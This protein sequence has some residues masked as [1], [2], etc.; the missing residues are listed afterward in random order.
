MV[1]PAFLRK[2]AILETNVPERKRCFCP[3]P[4]A[5]DGTCQE[6]G[7]ATG[8]ASRYTNPGG[9]MRL[10]TDDNCHGPAR[11]SGGCPGQC[12]G[13]DRSDASS[14]RGS[15]SYSKRDRNGRRLPSAG[16]SRLFVSGGDCYGSDAVPSLT[17]QGDERVCA[18]AET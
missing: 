3:D 11:L 4:P 16:V 18:R 8:V 12:P 2:G 5:T 15:R 14:R 10:R 9:G 6:T 17:W 7:R 13:D 1:R